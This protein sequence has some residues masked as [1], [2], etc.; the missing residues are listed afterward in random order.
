MQSIASKLVIIAVALVLQV[1]SG[2]S[3]RG[4]TIYYQ[5]GFAR[6]GELVGTAPDTTNTGGATWACTVGT[7]TYST[8][9]G[10]AVL[11][12]SAY[13][14][15]AAFLPINGTSGVTVDGTK[16]FTLSVTVTPGSAGT[17]GIALST[18]LTA[19]SY[20]SLGTNALAAIETGSGYLA[21]Y[22]Y[23]G[24]STNYNFGTGISGATTVSL[25]YSA[26][27]GTLTYKVGT[28][29]VLTQSGV[30]AS[31]IAALRDV[32]FGDQGYGGGAATPAPTFDNFLFVV[33]SGTG[34]APPAP[35]GLGA[36]AGNAQVSLAWTAST[37][38]T[39][40]NIYRGTTAGGESTT[41]IATG[42]TTASYTDSGLTNGTTYYYKVSAVNSSGTSGYSNEASATPSAGSPPPAPTGLGATA[43]N[44][45]VNLSWTASAGATSYNVYRGT[46]A[47]GESTTAIAT[48]I[49]TT[50]Y[51]NT[52]LTNGTTYYY[53]VA[54][55][56]AVGTSGYSNE[57]SATPAT[58]GSTTYYQDS[59]TRSGD[60]TGSTP[61]VINTGGATWGNAAGSGQYPISSGT[62]SI[63]SSAYSWS[64]EYL[65]V[66]GTSG[67]T[68]DGTKDFTLS[69]VVTSG[70]TGRSGIC[71]STAAPGNLFDHDFAALSTCSG[72]AG[73]Y[74]FNG[75]TINYNYAAGITGPT[76][77]SLAYSASAAT[78][79]YTVGSTVVYTQTGVTTAQVAAIR[80][81]SL[82][83]DGYGGGAAAPAPT[84]D[85]FTFTVG[86]GGGG[87]PPPAPTGLA[88]TPGNTQVALT[89]NVSSGATGYNVYRGTTAGGES[90][91]A[92]ATGITALS[93][94][95][96]GLSNGTAYYY[97]VTAVNSSGTSGYSNEANATPSG[98][99]A[100][101][102]PTGLAATAGNAQIGLSW[103][104]SSGATSY[105]VY[106]GTTA[107]GEGTTAIATGITTTT[108]TNTG[109]TNGTA[110]YYKVA[111]VNSVG[112][113]GYSNEAS[114]SPTAGG[115]STT[116]YQDSFTRTG[117]VTGSAPDVS[118]TGGAIWGNSAGTGQYP[119]SGGT[120]S[121]APAAYS[122]S[123]EYLP[124]N[125]TSGITL[126]G[127]KDFTLSVAVTSASTGRIGISLNTA[128]PGNLF[129]HDLAALST[130]SGFAGAYAF[131]G[132]TI[133]YNYAAGISGQ[134]TISLAYSESAATLTYTVGS[135]T[136]YTQTGVTTAQVAAVRYVAL[137][138][139]GYGGGAATPAPTFDNFTFTVGTGGGSAPSAPTGLAATPG[140]AQV[141]L[142]W[143]AS[144]GATSYNVYRGTTA[145]GE[146][147]TAIATGVTTPSYT[148]TGL[149]NGTA[150]YYKVAAVNGSGTSAYSNEATATPSG[151]SA[152]SSPTGLAAT[153]GNAQVGLTWSTSAGATSYNVYR[154]TTAG[155]E[156]TTAIAT[157]LTSAAYTDS[158]VTNGTAYYYKVAAVNSV[159][160]SGYSNE[161]SATPT[162]GSVPAAP[163]GLAATAGN[164]QVGLSWTASS[165][166]TSYNLYRGTSAGEESGTAVATGI[167]TTTYT[168]T[169]LTNGTA[170]YYKVAAVNSV[171]TSG[172]SNE[173][174]ATP[175]S[176]GGTTYALTVY[177]GS[178]SG[179]YAAGAVV[180]VAANAAPSGYVF[181]GWTGNTGALANASSAT[182]TLT[183]PATATSVQATYTPSS[184]TTYTL[185]VV[186]GTGGGNYPAGKI[187]TISA[188]GAPGGSQFSRWTGTT[189]ALVLGD[190]DSSTTTITMPSVATTVTATYGAIAPTYAVTVTSGTGGGS[191]AAGTVVPISA[192]AA[193]SGNHFSG[194][195]GTTGALANAS[196]A[197]TTLTVPASAASVTANYVANGSTYAL[198]V[199]SGSGSGSYNPGTAVAITANAPASGY[200]FAGWTGSTSYL[201]NPSAPTTTFN[202]PSAAASVTATYTVINSTANLVLAV[203]MERIVPG[204]NGPAIR[205]QRPSD[206]TQ[207]DIGFA[208]GSNLLDT[209][210]VS[211]FLGQTQGWITTLYAQDGSGHNVGTPLPTSTASMPTISAID[212]T[213]ISVNG[214]PNLTARNVEQPFAA[215][216]GNQRYFVLPPSVAVNKSQMS[217]F[218]A[219]RP[220]FSG[221]GNGIPY[222][223]L[224]EVGDPT[225]DAVD[226]MSCSSGL[227][228]L[229]HNSTVTYSN[230]NVVQRSQPTVIGL[231]TNPGSAPTLYLDGVSYA[232]GGTAPASTT[233][234]GGYLLAG[235][236]SGLYYG[237]PLFGQYNFLAFALYSGTVVPSTATT[238]STA[239]LPHAAPTVNIVADGD[240]ITQGT[241]SVYN[242]NML[243]YLE[244]QLNHPADITNLAIFGTTSPSA[245]GHAT[246]PTAATSVD[247]MHYSS[248]YAKNIY[249]LD[250]GTN[251]IHG[252]FSNGAATWAEVQTALQDAK[253]LGYK[254]VVTTLLHEN[255]ENPAYGAE[256]DNFNALARAAVGQPYLD[257]LIDYAADPRLG[258]IG[259]Y[260]PAFSGDG[261]HPNDA[262]YQ[263]MST[264][265]APVINGLIGP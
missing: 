36:T 93:Y 159:G 153:P 91:T 211:S 156:S 182:T 67:I 210:A 180:T 69:V 238:I 171:G 111:A 23:N 154:G 22:S 215:V 85:N 51:S 237:I 61:D 133:N 241:G 140:N 46:T 248:S 178:G 166:A 74:A 59:F 209:S 207:T 129:D 41:A 100:P 17:T 186:G 6:S 115:G 21:A 232:S 202:M 96:T 127:T 109:L 84:F 26:S 201:S 19:N 261:T 165:G 107:G 173:A 230:N 112:T 77:I 191:Y 92:V 206:N 24:G 234:S 218:L 75:G 246:Y 80:Y 252:G 227:Q 120:A 185:T 98:G 151:G 128:A 8:S 147:T 28:T 163:T 71:L 222:M 164:A 122:W 81:V 142:T 175:T 110:Y 139:D 103:T 257:G 136:V 102:A 116:Y 70:S 31:Q 208:A 108:Y 9:S 138:D 235:T 33:G 30:T 104:A 5:D 264:I 53:K 55:L 152:P 90:T 65:P 184:G 16:D 86:S 119:I 101:A 114:A 226:I 150:Y 240:S 167:T 231:T 250:I 247:A 146:S 35:T 194:W 125:G 229:T 144:S 213:A 27:A 42:V 214:S 190:A 242:Y 37:G 73:A 263:V 118:N 78:V 149:T 181:A 48:G 40:Y 47:A 88:A 135:T 99:S 82:G 105:N 44:A 137:G 134:T 79:T 52:G 219:F 63:A 228:G 72:F 54:A 4:Q 179:N 265:A 160:T 158:G 193:P 38:A 11:S 49:T 199:N 2:L 183:M 89:W 221:S 233:C 254:T 203:G 76:T 58:G 243:H 39:S 197:S 126:D 143:T 225:V 29:V 45:L 12:T 176:G 205:I 56:N 155:G 249:Y 192:N 15:N 172:Y 25:A 106:R 258:N 195:T 224:F 50:S 132:G 168:D 121:I 260:Y 204:Y 259:I 212:P 94:T 68:V 131:N 245:V 124:V 239:M 57:A 66:N 170:Y 256:I 174:S 95:D 177:Q 64:A 123:A 148:N 130:C 13:S 60:V 97:K 162:G 220:D 188:N 113:S 157:G 43:G 217:V 169:G 14:F 255:G 187:V 32:A 236:G 244:P 87:S 189:S 141:G 216:Q 18:G 200:Q 10:A 34:S 262:G 20:N 161:A 62:A 223:S 7:G 3:S 145:G 251:D 117:D 253:A 83:D 196:F 198:T 1:T